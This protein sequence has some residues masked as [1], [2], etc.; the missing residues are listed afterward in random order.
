MYDPGRVAEMSQ[1]A[2]CV[3]D[4]SGVVTGGMRG[5]RGSAKSADAPAAL[6]VANAKVAGEDTPRPFALIGADE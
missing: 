3:C 6:K 4:P 1:T 2:G 5:F